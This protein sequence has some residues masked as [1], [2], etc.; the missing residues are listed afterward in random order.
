M[1][2]PAMFIFICKVLVF[3]LFYED[4]FDVCDS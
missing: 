4:K 3:V 2:G 1:A